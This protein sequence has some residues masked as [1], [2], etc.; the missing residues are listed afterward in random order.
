M[1]LRYEWNKHKLVMGVSVLHLRRAR[2]HALMNV[3]RRAV[4]EPNA[5]LTLGDDAY[6]L[7]NGWVSTSNPY[8]MWNWRGVKRDDLVAEADAGKAG[9]ADRLADYDEA[10]QK[11]AAFDKSGYEFPFG[12]Y[13]ED[14]LDMFGE[15]DPERYPYPVS[16]PLRRVRNIVLDA[17]QVVYEGPGRIEEPQCNW[18][19]NAECTITMVENPQRPGVVHGL[20]EF[21]AGVLRGMRR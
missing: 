19:W 12:A 3:N 17:W 2:Y 4:F 7:I 20:V 18:Q 14:V 9:A 11:Q 8:A 6:D 1:K 16:H 21:D 13:K 10:V 15:A 5:Q